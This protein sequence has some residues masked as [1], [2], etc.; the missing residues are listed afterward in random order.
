MNIMS[1]LSTFDSTQFISA[2]V[3][4][5][6]I[7]DIIGTLPIIINLRHNGRTVNAGKASIISLCLFLGFMYM[8]NAF[9]SLFSLDISSFA[10]AGSIIIFIISMEMILDI[11][12]FHQDNQ[13]GN[14]ATFTPVVFPLI[15]GAGAFTTLLSIRSQYTDLNII[16]AILLNVIIIYAAL[17]AAP[18]LERHLSLGIVCIFQ[19]AF[20][21][22]L[23][24][25]SVKLFTSNLLL[26]IH[27]AAQ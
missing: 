18:K 21:I 27:S 13:S 10:I 16:L 8:G 22:I 11:H 24:S 26:F 14:D 5:F 2:F 1:F 17:K 4:L 15:A 20:G 9:L 12:I 6:A 3:V 25:I 19:K 7:I 23:L